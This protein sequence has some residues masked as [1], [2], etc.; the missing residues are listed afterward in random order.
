MVLVKLFH[1]ISPHTKNYFQFWNP[2]P[3]CD[4]KIRCWKRNCE[5]DLENR[6]ELTLTLPVVAICVVSYKKVRVTVAVQ[7][8]RRRRRLKSERWQSR[9]FRFGLIVV[10]D[11][12]SRSKQPDQFVFYLKSNSPFIF[13]IWFE[14]V[15][16]KTTRLILSK[17]S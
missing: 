4:K 9:F 2:Y 17:K 6:K 5:F 3:A 11:I 13:Q 7:K 10:V 14:G 16:G 8:W 1:S 12:T 15:N